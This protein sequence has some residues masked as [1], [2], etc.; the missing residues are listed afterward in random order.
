MNLNMY[1]FGLEL[2]SLVQIIQYLLIEIMSTVCISVGG[3]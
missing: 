3:K 2:L 1:E